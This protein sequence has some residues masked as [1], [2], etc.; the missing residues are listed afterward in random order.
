MQEVIFHC[1]WKFLNNLASRRPKEVVCSVNR[2][3][4]FGRH[5]SGGTASVSMF[6]SIRYRITLYRFL[7]CS[8]WMAAA[9]QCSC[10]GHL[11]ITC[12]KISPSVW[13]GCRRKLNKCFPA[14]TFFCLLSGTQN[15]SS[16]KL[17]F[18]FRRSFPE[19]PAIMVFSQGQYSC[20]HYWRRVRS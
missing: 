13:L 18:P 5:A 19:L 11:P 8:R 1:K 3:G 14:I 17:K 10:R 16:T 6:L 12:A 2:L 15:S 7:S 9:S 20:V 4:R